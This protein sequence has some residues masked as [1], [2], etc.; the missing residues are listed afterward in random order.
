MITLKFNESEEKDDLVKFL[1]D[2]EGEFEL[3]IYF[4]IPKGERAMSQR[5]RMLMLAGLEALKDKHPK[6]IKSE[7]KSENNPTLKKENDLPSSWT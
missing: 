5:A 6:K 7:T 3:P 1:K 4:S 2:G